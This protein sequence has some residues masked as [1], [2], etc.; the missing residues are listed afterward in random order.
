MILDEPTAGLDLAASFD[1]VRRIRKL[2]NAGKNIVLVTHLLN[3]IPP[4]ID[5]II[6]L[7]K[8]KIVA[9]GAKQAVLTEENL[10]KTYDTDINIA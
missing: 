2:A 5:R 9:D 7:R 8:G 10:R 6:L 1:Y 4:D 3:E